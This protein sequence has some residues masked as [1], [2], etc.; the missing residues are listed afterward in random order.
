MFENPFA[1]PSIKYIV[2][3]ITTIIEK[4]ENMNTAI[5]SLLA[6]ML[7]SSARAASTNRTKRRTR[8]T[9]ITRKIRNVAKSANGRARYNG[10]NIDDSHGAAYV[11]AWF[12]KTTDTKDVLDGKDKCENSFERV[13]CFT[14]F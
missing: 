4:T 5:R 11:F 14:I 12:P 1:S 9:R 13:D 6:S 7:S 3:P 8:K 10:R 2:H